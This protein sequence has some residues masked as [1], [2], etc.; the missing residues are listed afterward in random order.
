MDR[1]PSCAL[2]AAARN[3]IPKTEFLAQLR[4][5]CDEVIT[6]DNEADWDVFADRIQIIAF[7]VRTGEGASDIEEACMVTTA[8][9][10]VFYFAISPHYLRM[11]VRPLNGPG[12]RQIRHV[13]LLRSQWAMI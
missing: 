8:V 2:I 3:A 10:R 9:P 7:N 4:P 11:R 12:S 13:W 6:Q 5:F 1:F